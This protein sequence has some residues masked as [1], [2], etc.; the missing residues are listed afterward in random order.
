[1]STLSQ[2]EE[3]AM[4]VSGL[5][6]PPTREPGSG[7]PDTVASRPEVPTQEGQSLTGQLSGVD[8]AALVRADQRSRWLRGERVPAEAYLERLPALAGY[9]GALTELIHNE[10]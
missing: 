6:G 2:S 7:C 8:L 9:P 1:M 10:F 5:D 4:S 3:T